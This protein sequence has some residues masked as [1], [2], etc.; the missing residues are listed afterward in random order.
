MME[1]NGV[2]FIYD[3]DCPICSMA[4]HALRL[5]EQYGRVTL[6]NAREYPDHPLLQ[7]V[8]AR[9]LDLDDG[10]VIVHNQHFYHGQDALLFMAQ[11]GEPQAGLPWRSRAGFNH[12]IRLFRWRPLSRLAYPW[13]RAIRNGLLRLRQKGPIDNLQR[14]REPIF[15]PVFGAQ[16][17]ALPPVMK[18]HYAIRPYSTD[19]VIVDGV[20]DVVCLRPLNMARP[21]YRLLG[22]IPLTTEY[23]VR[24][25]VHFNSS[26][27]DRSF[28][29]V[30]HFWFVHQRFYRFRS[31]MLA[32][33]GEQVIEI[34]RFGFCWKMRY[35][36]EDDKVK[37]IHDGYGLYW[38]GHLIPLP[39]TWLLGRGDAEEWAIDDNRFAMNVTMTHP[40]FGTQYSYSGTF[41]VT[42]ALDIADQQEQSSGL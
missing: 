21:L 32:L 41:T 2:W 35:R 22:A 6:L 33:G 8:R 36:W 14:A 34:M 13:M 29:F 15:K 9:Q 42:Q 4:S 19:Q 25:T 27:R 31:R 5:K 10:M 17:D 16:W 37:L 12:F 40:L 3:G 39:V 28:G 20:M 1:S 18:K 38:F 11:H 24:C 23:S 26:L 30:R 7:E